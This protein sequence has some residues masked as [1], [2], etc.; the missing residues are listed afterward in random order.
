MNLMSL[1]IFVLQ[2]INLM[3]Y[4][5][6]YPY[7]TFTIHSP[8]S[9]EDFFQQCHLSK[10]TIHLL[11]QNKAYTVNKRYVSSSTILLK[12]D[13]FTIKAFEHDDGM[14][15]PDYQDLDIIYED[16][17]LLVVNKPAFINVFPDSKEKTDSLANRVSAYYLQQGYDL[18]I[19][20]IHR[21]DYET[22]GLVLFCKCALIQPLL[23]YQLSQKEI[24]RHYLAVVEG[25]IHDHKVHCICKPIAKDRHHNQR[26]RVSS[27]GKEAKTFYQC[28]A[29]KNHLSLVTCRLE[30]GRKHQIRVHMASI[31]HPLLGDSLYYQ[32]SPLI[33][34]QALHAYQ[35]KLIH[36]ITKEKMTLVCHPP[37]DM[38]KIISTIDPIL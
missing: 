14:Y 28:I 16:D 25:L 30:T 11:K 12:G 3:Q 36:P 22:S 37:K 29:S 21:L 34:R 8:I 26:M 35:L 6:H 10:K 1:L 15:P 18:P 38:K 7:I 23:D 32:R 13:L 20:F 33:N 17:F 4:K 31:G 2:S 5:I 19:R 9:I 27:S 24:E